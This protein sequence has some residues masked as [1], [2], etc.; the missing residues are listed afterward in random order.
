MVCSWGGGGGGGGGGGIAF[1][2]D[3]DSKHCKLT[4]YFVWLLVFNL[5]LLVYILAGHVQYTW[6][7][8]KPHPNCGCAQ[9]ACRA[10]VELIVTLLVFV[11]Q[12]N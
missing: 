4:F 2:R 12:D 11:C 5:S 6:A 9:M 1:L 10:V 8:P 3:S 7:D